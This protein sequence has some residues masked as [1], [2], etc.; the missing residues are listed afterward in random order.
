MKSNKL[1]I[2]SISLMIATPAISLVSCG[3]T[4]NYFD[5]SPALDDIQVGNYVKAEP[6]GYGPFLYRYE[7]PEVVITKKDGQFTENDEIFISYMKSK[8]SYNVISGTDYKLEDAG[9]TT[10]WHGHD[11]DKFA[12]EMGVTVYAKSGSLPTS[13]V[14]IEWQYVYS[15]KVE[16]KSNG[17]TIVTER[18]NNCKIKGKLEYTPE[19]GISNEIK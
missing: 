15:I 6:S 11:V 3:A 2:P 1:L 14:S 18:I 7:T 17:K 16:Y 5:F 10:I 9:A 12:Y 4:S 13:S 19:K 8:L